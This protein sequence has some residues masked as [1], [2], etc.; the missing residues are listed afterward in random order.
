MTTQELRRLQALLK[1]ADS[2]VDMRSRLVDML[3][4]IDQDVRIEFETSTGSRIDI[5]ADLMPTAF[6]AIR[7]GFARMAEIIAEACGHELAKLQ[8]ELRK[9]GA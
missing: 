2:L 5:S 8:D 7:Q 1:R 9:G 3:E 4:R 6:P